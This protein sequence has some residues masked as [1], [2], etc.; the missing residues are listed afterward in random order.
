VTASSHKRTSG[1]WGF[2]VCSIRLADTRE[3]RP[4][5]RNRPFTDIRVIVEFGNEELSRAVQRA[6]E[7]DTPLTLILLDIDH[8]KAINDNPAM[9]RSTGYCRISPPICSVIPA[10][11]TYWPAGAGRSSCSCCRIPHWRTPA[12]WRST[13][14]LPQRKE[15]PAGRTDHC[16]P[17]GTPLEPEDNT[18]TIIKCADQALYESKKAGRNR[19]TVFGTSVSA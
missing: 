1:W 5:D 15:L 8:F 4:N 7:T 16:Q 10:E 3:N 13:S 18:E 6:R 11:A 14:Y 12:P 9:T 2:S 19:T 17:R